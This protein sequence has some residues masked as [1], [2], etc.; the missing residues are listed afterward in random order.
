MSENKKK[1][2]KKAQV[3][4]PVIRITNPF[5]P[6]EF[7][8]EQIAWNGTKSLLDYFP[9]PSV[10]V[11]ISING[12]IVPREEYASTYLGRTDNIVVCPIPTGGDSGKGVLRV[13]AMIAISVYAPQLAGSM[14]SA[15]G[16]TYV[17][18]SA[19]MTLGMLS[20]GVVVA[21][22][23]LVSSIFAAPQPTS[24]T[25]SSANTSSYGID[26]AKNT[27]LES[28]PVPVC[29]GKFRMGGNILGLHV[30]NDADD[31]QIL[32]ILLSAG[33]GKVV[34]LSDVEIN[35]TPV[36]DFKDV[37]VQ[38]R[39]GLASQLPI[40]WFNDTIVAINKGQKLTQ[41]WFYSTTTTAV[42]KMR[43]DFVAPN[44]LCSFDS[45]TG[46]AL[47]YSVDLEMQYRVDGSESA[48]LPMPSETEVSKWVAVSKTEVEDASGVPTYDMFH[49]PIYPTKTVWKTVRGDLLS[50]FAPEVEVTDPAAL[51]YLKTAP[52]TLT[53]DENGQPVATSRYP[54]YI[55]TT[56]MTSSK[57]SAVRKSFSTSKLE[58]HKYEVR[59]R[60][61]S[62]DSME[63]AVLD[64]I[65]FSDL[66]EIVLDTLSYS[67]TALVGLRVR[68][69][70]QLSG[71]PKVTYIN[72]GR[73]L[74]V[75]GKPTENQA[76]QWFEDASTNPAWI[77]WDILTNRRFGGAMPSSRIDFIAFRDWAKYCEDT[78]LE[79]N[80]VIDTEMNVW[81]AM[82]LVLRV[83]HAQLVNVGTRWTVV[84]ERATDPVMM[85][86]VANMVDGSYK[87]TWLGTADRANEID[88]TFFDKDDS[89]KQR[90]VKIYDPV[91][92]RSG[93]KQRS[94][95]ITLFGVTDYETAYKEAQFQ[96]NLNRY[97]LKTVNFSAPMEAVAC[98]VGDLVYVQHDMTE[99]AVAGRFERG[100]TTSVMKLDRD[101]SMEAGKQYKILITHDSVQRGTGGIYNV[102][103]TSL[104][105]TGYSGT[106]KAK[107]INVNGRD[108]RVAGTF[109]QGSGYGVVVDSAEGISPG[110]TYA[111]WDTDVI[112]EYNV[113]NHPGKSSSLT[114]QSPASFEP[115]QYGNWMFGEAE[116][117]KNL[118]RIKSVSGGHDYTRDIT[119]IEY[120]PEVYDFTRYGE[121]TPVIP[122]KEGVIG[123]VRSL[124]TYEETYVSGSNIVSKVVASWRAPITG[125]YAGA[126]V[127]VKKNDGAMTKVS[128]SKVM[129]STI[130]DAAKG[131]VVVV[132]VVAYDI[133]GK[134]SLYELAPEVKY[135]VIGEISGIDVG[136]VTGAG[137]TWSGRDCKINWRYNSVTHAY[138]FGSEPVGAD[139]GSLDPHFKDY[140]VR[141]YS[142]DH[143]TLR[144]TEYTTDNSYVYI[145][146]KNFADG[147]SRRLVFEVRMRDTFNNLGSPATL[148]AYNPPPKVLAV[149]E[150]ATFESATI[151]Y[152][153][154]EDPDF[155]G[156]MIWLSRHQ[157]DLTDLSKADSMVVYKG[158]DS[159]VLL[160]NLMFDASYY[161]RIAAYD[162]FGTTELLPTATGHFKTTFLNV[163]AIAEGVL[164]DSVLVPVLRERINLVDGPATMAGSV[165]AR[166]LAE[167]Q[168][169]DAAVTIETQARESATESL[170][171]SISMV[172]AKTDANAA[173]ILQEATARTTQVSAVASQVD[174]VAVK[175]E[176]NAASI[177]SEKTAR[178]TSDNALSTSIQAVQSS[179]ANAN[180]LITSEQNARASADNALSQSIYTVSSTVNSHTASIQTVQS[181]VNGLG[182]QYTVKIDN[183][184][185]VTGYGLAS[186]TVNGAPTSEFI[187]NAD[188]FAVVIPGYPSENPFTIG[189][190]NG[191]YRTIIKDAIIR[192]GAISTAKIGTAQVNTLSIAGNAVTLPFY[193]SF[194]ATSYGQQVQTA[195]QWL[196]AGSKIIAIVTHTHTHI[197]GYAAGAYVGVGVY[198][199]GETVIGNSSF[200]YQNYGNG[201]TTGAYTATQ[202]GWHCVYV[203]PYG[204][205]GGYASSVTITAMGAQR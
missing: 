47:P 19:S 66:N 55:Q 129:T 108:L 164:K 141:I 4:I 125:M 185:Y 31:N 101:V 172:T 70:D 86:S 77:V 132:R 32:Y 21:G 34:S 117:V 197:G 146:D 91:S 73:I 6:R 43:L 65:Y 11:I 61:T 23:L 184:G 113:V 123:P 106:S 165:A 38:T 105:L 160:P 112:E 46:G 149:S 161:F 187:V 114:L 40:P 54:V 145:Y 133:F 96:L 159:S 204:D 71:L 188:K 49:Q 44:G 26:G 166:I 58:P 155:A 150:V 60:R 162:V 110:D 85:F 131:D 181:S 53:T 116:K 42:D 120:R 107:R 119:A 122:P 170:A 139:A 48:W 183:N 103:G 15:M 8:N 10:E 176:E 83:G 127:Y 153:H 104:F 39:L 128:D 18:A 74:N 81:D 99:W 203:I 135:T 118:F 24:N 97:I 92:L 200:A 98:S 59:V 78:G 198:G 201:V 62:K 115:L 1:R 80:G 182:A 148:E 50:G 178:T 37:E 35:D 138:E 130:I 89:Y 84:V 121:N 186:T 56:R 41:D 9:A 93:A 109:N 64:D 175:T 157:D 154:S 137:F 79:W 68:L 33:E 13:V 22:S 194:G 94:S 90:T 51:E 195:W 180:A 193:S 144:R 163:D 36:S 3:M 17:A 12:K 202:A 102:I 2:T 196:D 136:G 88:V 168:A 20:A 25:S 191:T 76:E 57:R 190:V 7:V 167:A 5:N 134:R 151:S 189:L 147:L 67:N 124:Q 63:T 142:G 158:P 126:D 152:T 72:G 156:A 205:A 192:D 111:L 177:Y 75:Y 69:T 87:E 169:R 100:S 27:S 14:Y 29:Y 30:D 140:E 143:L 28:I 95:A 16:G 52:L 199:V 82:Q 171:N 173:A 179:V 45:A 174:A